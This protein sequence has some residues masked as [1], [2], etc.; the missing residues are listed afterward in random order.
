[1]VFRNTNV[2]IGNVTLYDT[3]TLSLQNFEAPNF[4][5]YPNPSNDSWTISSISQEM[6]SIEIYNLLGKKVKSLEPNSTSVNI[7]GS[8]LTS[9]IYT[10]NIAINLGVISKKLFKQ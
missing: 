7:D 1:V 10:M 3:A 6:R 9:G 5:V 2:T 8:D 4:S